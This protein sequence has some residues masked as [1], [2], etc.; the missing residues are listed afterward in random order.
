MDTIVITSDT[1]DRVPTDRYDLFKGA[2]SFCYCFHSHLDAL[3][4]SLHLLFMVSAV[5]YHGICYFTVMK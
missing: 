1:F 4:S 5:F 3:E 2:E